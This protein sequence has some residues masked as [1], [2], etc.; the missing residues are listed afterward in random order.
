MSGSNRRVKARYSGHV[1]VRAN[2]AEPIGKQ[3]ASAE[4]SQVKRF[5][6]YWEIAS[7][8]SLVPKSHNGSD[9]GRADRKVRDIFEQLL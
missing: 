2:H 8:G 4:A 9:I 5:L 6:Q 3:L 1:S 7:D